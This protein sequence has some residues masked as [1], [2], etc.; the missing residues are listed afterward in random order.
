MYPNNQGG[1]GVGWLNSVGLTCRTT[2][3][4]IL[5]LKHLQMKMKMPA[6][7]NTRPVVPVRPPFYI[8]PED[9]LMVLLQNS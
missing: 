8:N 2:F 5:V 6:I 3:R 9:H 1:K 4:S 7:V